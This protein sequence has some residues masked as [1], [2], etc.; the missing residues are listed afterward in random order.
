MKAIA[1]AT[2]LAITS[3]D[4]VKSI[5]PQTTAGFEEN[6]IVGALDGASGAVVAGCRSLDAMRLAVDG[7]AIATGAGD[8]V[9]DMRAARMRACAVAGA[10][11]AVRPGAAAAPVTVHRE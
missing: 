6:G 8:V 3:C 2:A 5:A 9:D 10:V 4:T 11:Q 7:L 1:I